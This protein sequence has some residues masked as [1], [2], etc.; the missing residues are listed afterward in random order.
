MIC[1][2]DK[3]RVHYEAIMAILRKLGHVD[4]LLNLDALFSLDGIRVCYGQCEKLKYVTGEW[5]KS[6]ESRIKRIKP[7]SDP[8]CVMMLFC[9]S[10]WC[11]A[12]SHPYFCTAA[13]CMMKFYLKDW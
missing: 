7:F 11:C 10:V 8:R 9:R 6:V 1:T 12:L 4:S 13:E 2:N 5:R 3:S